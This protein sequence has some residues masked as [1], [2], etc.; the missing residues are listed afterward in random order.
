MKKPFAASVVAVALALGVSGCS[1]DAECEAFITENSAFAA[2]VK[3]AHEK[4]G[5]DGARK[6]FDGKK[7]D[8]KKKWDGIKEARGFQL[9]DEMMKKLQENVAAT[10]GDVCGLGDMKLCTDYTDVLK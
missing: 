3:A 7:D 1:K 5:A 2:A 4:D 8:L 10:L 9:K 6:A